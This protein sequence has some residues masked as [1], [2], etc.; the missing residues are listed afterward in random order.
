MANQI[1][2]SVD[3]RGAENERDC[4]SGARREFDVF[5]VFEV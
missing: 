3:G 2:E 4:A 1:G 5:D